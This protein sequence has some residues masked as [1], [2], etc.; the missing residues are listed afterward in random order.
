MKC[1][2]LCSIIASSVQQTLELEGALLIRWLH[3]R[4][5]GHW[6]DLEAL[7]EQGE[8]E[9]KVTV[10]ERRGEARSSEG[11]S[12]ERGISQI[13]ALPMRRRSVAATQV[14]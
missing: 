5:S 14:W 2:Q 3:I 7:V 10:A 11:R 6:E 13:Y 1:C 9:R 12:G 8:C 4:G